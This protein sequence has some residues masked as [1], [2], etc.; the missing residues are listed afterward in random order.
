MSV[1]ISSMLKRDISSV[2]EVSMI[3]FTMFYQYDVGSRA[4]T[5]H[6]ATN[7]FDQIS[8]DDTNKTLEECVKEAVNITKNNLK[9]KNI[10]PIKI[11]V[12]Q[13][14]ISSEIVFRWRNLNKSFEVVSEQEILC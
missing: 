9:F 12:G 4:G 6:I 7:Q 5:N 14:R 8:L 11:I 3:Y 2:H 1:S 13:Y 10:T